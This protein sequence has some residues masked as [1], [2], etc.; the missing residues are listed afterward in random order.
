MLT[1]RRG[2]FALPRGVIICSGI[3]LVRGYFRINRNITGA[4]VIQFVSSMEGKSTHSD[5]VE[6]VFGCAADV[7]E[8]LE[9]SWVV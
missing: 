4:H 2:L 3:E 7:V 8:A 6:C 1:T 9:V 5:T